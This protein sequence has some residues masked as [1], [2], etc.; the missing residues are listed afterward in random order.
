MHQVVLAKALDKRAG[1][2]AKPTGDSIILELS[3]EHRGRHRASH[4]DRTR[5]Q[6]C[7]SLSNYSLNAYNQC[8]LTPCPDP[9]GVGCTS[10]IDNILYAVTRGRPQSSV[11]YMAISDFQTV[12]RS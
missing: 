3:G 12:V 1:L 5:R 9:R 7:V 2:G 4:S 8:Q 6:L 11:G 10:V